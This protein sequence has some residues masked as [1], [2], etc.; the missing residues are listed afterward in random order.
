MKDRRADSIMRA[1]EDLIDKKIF[2]D[3][4]FWNTTSTKE[5]IEALKADV[6]N[7]KAILALEL[8]MISTTDED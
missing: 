8:S 1:V 5:M 6:D 7:S 2:Y 4:A 3:R